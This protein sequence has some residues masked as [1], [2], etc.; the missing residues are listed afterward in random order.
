MV[1]NETGAVS[2]TTEEKGF[3]LEYEGTFIAFSSMQ[4]QTDVQNIPKSLHTIHVSLTKATLY[5]ILFDR[6]K[7]DHC[8]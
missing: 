6:G 2:N 1:A 5:Y 7:L 3:Q 8:Q 4:K